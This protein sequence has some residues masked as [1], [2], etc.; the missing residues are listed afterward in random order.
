MVFQM[1]WKG[2]INVLKKKILATLTCLC[3]R[4]LTPTIKRHELIFKLLATHSMFSRMVRKK[5]SDWGT[6][7]A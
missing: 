1:R 7:H 3:G 6:L 5:T 2:K 4:G